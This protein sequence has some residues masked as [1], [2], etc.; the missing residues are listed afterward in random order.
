MLKTN[1][2]RICSGFLGNI[3]N[4]KGV[5]H[6]KAISKNDFKMRTLNVINADK[7]NNVTDIV[8]KHFFGISKK[9]GMVLFMICK[10]DYFSVETKSLHSINKKDTSLCWLCASQNSL[11]NDWLALK[12]AE[13]QWCFF[14]SG[15]LWAGCWMAKKH[16]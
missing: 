11:N 9:S 5:L 6:N 10:A 14:A 16:C 3:Q 1:S 12:K 7:A 15:F 2:L 8:S 13:L 4:V